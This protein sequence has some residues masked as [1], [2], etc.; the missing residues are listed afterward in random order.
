MAVTC[1]SLRKR[2][3]WAVCLDLFICN[4]HGFSALSLFL[5][6]RK[7]PLSAACVHDLFAWRAAD[8]MRRV[9]V[10]LEKAVVRGLFG[11]SWIRT[12]IHAYIH[13]CTHECM[14]TR[15][16]RQRVVAQDTHLLWARWMLFKSA[17]LHRMAAAFTQMHAHIHTYMS[18]PIR[19]MNSAFKYIRTCI[20]VCSNTLNGCCFMSWACGVGWNF[21]GAACRMFC[22]KHQTPQ[23]NRLHT[24]SYTCM[25]ETADCPG[26]MT[27]LWN[28]SARR[29]ACL[30]GCMYVC[31]YVC[32]SKLTHIHI[33]IHIQWF[34]THL[35][36]LC[37]YM[38]VYY[39]SLCA[40]VRI[41]RLAPQD[42]AIV[43]LFC[44]VKK[45]N[46]GRSRYMNI[47][48]HIYIHT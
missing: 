39:V 6:L 5:W 32:I 2:S 11:S 16:Y 41:A 18:V 29:T 14:H 35:L 17:P 10:W 26:R 1:P 24:H 34:T 22:F 44:N 37:M 42:D 28:Q 8:S 31:M 30:R 12:Y 25:H 23:G 46:A 47:Y 38:H 40:I 3:W 9:R 45:S 21:S 33:H 36:V 15:T 48:T 13:T 43:H 27:K 19:W 7:R 20:H 4:S